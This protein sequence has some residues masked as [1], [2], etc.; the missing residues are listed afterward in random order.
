MAVILDVRKRAPLAGPRSR[1]SEPPWRGASWSRPAT[2]SGG[3]LAA[4]RNRRSDRNNQ[5]LGYRAVWAKQTLP[6]DAIVYENLLETAQYFIDHSNN[7]FNYD[8]IPEHAD[9]Y[10]S[11][12]F[13]AGLLD[14]SHLLKPKTSSWIYPGWNK[15]IPHF[16]FGVVP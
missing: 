14:A 11:N 16:F 5:P 7:I 9:S 4:A 1:P 2:V 12:S 13:V 8:C 6:E 10:N 15:P 3:T